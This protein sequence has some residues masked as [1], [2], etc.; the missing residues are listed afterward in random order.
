LSDGSAEY[1]IKERFRKK[2][3][4]NN[5]SNK[6]ITEVLRSVRFKG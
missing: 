6:N 2:L 5:T 1:K 3:Y 4:L